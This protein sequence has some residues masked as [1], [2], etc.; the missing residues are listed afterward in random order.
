[1]AVIVFDNTRGLVGERLTDEE[2][3]QL[4]A[5]MGD[6]PQDTLGHRYAF[7]VTIPLVSEEGS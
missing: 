1:M 4:F 3:A 2:A 6:S 7:W 5:E